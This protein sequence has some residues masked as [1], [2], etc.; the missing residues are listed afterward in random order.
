MT[1]DAARQLAIDDAA[2]IC[3]EVVLY[4]CVPIGKAF[5]RIVFEEA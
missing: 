3:G 1:I 2:A 5:P 4:R